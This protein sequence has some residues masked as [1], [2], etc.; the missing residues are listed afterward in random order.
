MLKRTRA[1]NGTERHA[2]AENQRALILDSMP[3][4]TS[5]GRK[6]KGTNLDAIVVEFEVE[7]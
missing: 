1:K 4:E 6:G 7:V 3:R 5:N 2:Q